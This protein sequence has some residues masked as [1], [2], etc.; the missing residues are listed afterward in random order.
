[1]YEKLLK[2]SESVNGPDSVMNAPLLDTLAVLQYRGRSPEK[3]ERHYKRALALREA[4]AGSS[5]DDLARSLYNL[6]EFY[7]LS[8]Q[9]QK[10]EPLYLRSIELL[11]NQNP[12]PKEGIIKIVGS[13]KCLLYQSERRSEIK[14]FK[15]KF[16]NFF[17]N[18]NLGPTGNTLNGQALSLPKPE[19]PI[20]A[21]ERRVGDIVVVQVNID[22][23]GKVTAAK[24]I[25]GSLPEFGKSAVASALKAKFAPRISDGV[26]V[27]VTGELVYTFSIR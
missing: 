26:P 3:A 27:K 16:R 13:Y 6:A 12:L 22:E 7:R 21:R 1:L 9:F 11:Q 10:A 14:E 4:N 15:E 24:D 2:D 5:G 19:Y 8:G 17:D 20:Y 23:T 18:G 25:C